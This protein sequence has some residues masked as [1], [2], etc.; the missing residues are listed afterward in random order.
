M[1]YDQL[2]AE[3]ARAEQPGRGQ[4]TDLM[5]EA[6]VVDRFDQLIADDRI[7]VAHR[8]L[9]AMLWNGGVRITDALSLDVR[10]FDLGHGSI[11]LGYPKL[12]SDERVILLDVAAAALVREAAGG[13]PDGPLLVVNAR[14][15][16][17]NAAMRAARDLA[18]TSI[19]AFRVGGRKAR[20]AKI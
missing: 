7:P 19:H 13:R 5:A 2:A 17:R 9:W 4:R 3:A 8:A 1:R 6:L 15:L 14:A 11:T 18:G 10:D 20:E 12:E 16:S